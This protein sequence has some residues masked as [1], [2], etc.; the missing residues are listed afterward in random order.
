MGILQFQSHG[1]LVHVFLKCD[2][3]DFY[4]QV[5]EKFEKILSD[6]ST[7]SDHFDPVLN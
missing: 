1:F 6:S 3:F 5:T 2:A 4:N 7:F